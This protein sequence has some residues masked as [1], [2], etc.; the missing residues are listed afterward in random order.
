[1][2]FVWTLNTLEV[3]WNAIIQMLIV[4]SFYFRQKMKMYGPCR[5]MDGHYYRG[6]VLEM[7]N[8]GNQK[9]VTTWSCV[10]LLVLFFL[11]F[12][13]NIY[14]FLLR[15]CLN[16]FTFL[17]RILTKTWIIFLFTEQ[18]KISKLHRAFYYLWHISKEVKLIIAFYV[19]QVTIQFEDGVIFTT[20]AV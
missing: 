10:L 15:F 16:W 9:T 13:I 18:L 6:Q 3:T 19:F 1:M 14:Q 5:R 8:E 11:Y 2:T 17:F 20:K 7:C 4:Y 12:E